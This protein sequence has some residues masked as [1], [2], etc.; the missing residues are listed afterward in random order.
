[1]FA[2]SAR[3]ESGKNVWTVG[4]EDFFLRLFGIKERGRCRWRSFEIY[5][6]PRPKK[7]REEARKIAPR[8]STKLREEGAGKY[9]LFFLLFR[10]RAV[11]HKREKPE[12]KGE[13]KKKVLIST[14]HG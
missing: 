4:F 11:S 8:I 6:I 14:I 9:A 12:V 5:P 13:E 1:M 10:G 2:R 7:K 3:E